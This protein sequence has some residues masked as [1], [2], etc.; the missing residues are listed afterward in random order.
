MQRVREFDVIVIGG[1]LAGL[2]AAR[3]LGAAGRRV[4]VVEARDRLGGRAWVR[5]FADTTVEL[6]FGG[7]WVLPD[8]H[9]A[10]MAELA[11]YRIP[12]IATPPP[13]RFVN[14]LDGR[15]H[16]ESEIAAEE[17]AALDAAMR[18][19]LAGAPGATL[20]EI[21]SAADI[22]PQ[23]RA[24]ATAYTRYLAGADTSEVGAGAA[25]H[26]DSYGFG[27]PDHYSDKIAGG[28]RH[29]VE[30]I[31]SDAAADLRLGSA[32]TVVEQDEAGV[33][34][35]AADGTRLSAA[36]AVVA[37]PVNVWADIAFR[38]PLSE[39]KGTLAGDRHAGHSVKVWAL[40][41]GVP[42]VVR[43]LSDTGPIAYLRTERMLPGERSLLVGFGPA[44]GFHP[45]D[46]DEVERALRHFLPEV[47][48]LACDGHDWNGDRFSRGTWFAARP[49]QFQLIQQGAGD[50]EGR[51]VFAG[52]DLSPSTAGTL[53]GAVATGATAARAV[54]EV[55]GG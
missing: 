21:L 10:I 39:A 54:L 13:A 1:G 43:G 24:Y 35:T 7:T 29:L 12:T 5:R 23:A 46:R 25:Y 34:V 2:T 14:V 8:Q 53:D 3:D 26:E 52:G 40:V 27:D 44:P 48:V 28:T 22:T 32:V 20:A 9:P 36:A 31:A 6:D 45:T 41:T 38:P 15:P 50:P 11:R 18:A 55:V 4:V 42:D 30:A 47:A 37:L 17:L 51:L 49:G 19:G 16:T 33:A